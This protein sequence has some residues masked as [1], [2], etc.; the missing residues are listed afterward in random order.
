M[1]ESA[2]AELQRVAAVQM[3]SGPSVQA[4]LLE[5]ERLV[6]LAAEAGARLVVLPENFALMARRPADLIQYLTAGAN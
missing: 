5:A 2:P 6:V 3:V 4:N 1:S